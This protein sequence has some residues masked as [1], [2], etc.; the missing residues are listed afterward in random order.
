MKTSC[1]KDMSIAG[2]SL[3]SSAPLLYFSQGVFDVVKMIN[4]LW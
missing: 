2:F 1:T 3:K 4:I